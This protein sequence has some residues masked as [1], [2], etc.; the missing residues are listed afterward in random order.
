MI[1]ISPSLSMLDVGPDRS[2][3]YDILSHF[4]FASDFTNEQHTCLTDPRSAL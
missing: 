3:V 4:M 2:L 1:D